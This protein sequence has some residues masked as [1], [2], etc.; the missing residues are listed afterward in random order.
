MAKYQRCL[1]CG[2]MKQTTEFYKHR[3]FFGGRRARCK[4]CD[5]IVRQE[6]QQADYDR[7]NRLAPPELIKQPKKA[8]GKSSWYREKY[9]YNEDMWSADRL[10]DYKKYMAEILRS[11][12]SK[13]GFK[14]FTGPRSTKARRMELRASAEQYLKEQLHG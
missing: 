9:P 13:P 6:K 4:A 3:G 1:K 5:K 12:M 2:L 11:N 7:G 8:K 10:A 14:R